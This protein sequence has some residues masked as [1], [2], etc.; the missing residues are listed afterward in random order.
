M[1]LPLR[2]MSETLPTSSVSEMG[3]SNA[4]T[5]SPRVCSFATPEDPLFAITRCATN[6][7]LRL[8]STMS[9][10]E[11]SLLPTCSTRR[12]SPGQIVGSMLLPHARSRNS[13]GERTKEFA[14]SRWMACPWLNAGGSVLT[15][16]SG[17]QYN[18]PVSS[19]P[20][21]KKG[22]SSRT[23]AQSEKTAFRKAFCSLLEYAEYQEKYHS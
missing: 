20:S 7:P 8:N 14:S 23:P 17:E 13:P 16:R 11:T 15:R 1:C 5:A 12:V 19:L 21:R 3:P 4:T 10:S 2:T 6:R 18:W 22:Q 9:P